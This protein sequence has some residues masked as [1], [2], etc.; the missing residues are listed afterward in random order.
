MYTHNF[1]FAEG[2]INHQ[3]A[4]YHA[5]TRASF[6]TASEKYPLLFPPV[7]DAEICNKGGTKK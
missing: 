7:A 1:L 5:T 4:R 6:C 3:G 2:R